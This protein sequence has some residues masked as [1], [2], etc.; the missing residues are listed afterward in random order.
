MYNSYGSDRGRGGRGQLSAPVAS[1]TGDPGNAARDYPLVDPSGQFTGMPGGAYPYAM[2]P[3]LSVL[4]PYAPYGMAPGQPQSPWTGPHPTLPGPGAAPGM[5]H[6][7]MVHPMSQL[8]AGDKRSASIRSP[9][10]PEEPSKQQNIE[11]KQRQP[12]MLWTV[13][14]N[15]TLLEL[16]CEENYFNDIATGCGALP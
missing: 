7:H 13:K 2:H 8:R 6:G 12:R 9:D 11:E 4:P 5:P 16:M 10:K 15:N 3:Q 1:Y 14:Y